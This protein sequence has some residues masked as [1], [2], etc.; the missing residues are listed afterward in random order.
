MLDG[1][2]LLDGMLGT[3][4]GDGRLGGDVIG[5]QAANID[6]KRNVIRW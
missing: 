2:V 5:A 3:L 4:I 1:E 6:P